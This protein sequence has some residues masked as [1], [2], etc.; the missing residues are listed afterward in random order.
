MKL[1]QLVPAQQIEPNTKIRRRNLKLGRLS[2]V[3]P[4]PVQWLWPDRI[5]RKVVLFTGLPDCGKT[6]AAIDIAARVTRGSAWPDGSGIAPLGSVIFLTAEDGLA[7][8]IRTRAD[9]AGAD[10]SRIYFLEG[11]HDEKGEPSSFS[12]Q[13][14][15]ALLSEH[16]K[17]IGDVT[18]I[19]ID[20]ITAYLGA[21]KIDTHKTAVDIRRQGPSIVPQ[22]D[23]LATL[24]RRE[25]DAV[26]A[27]LSNEIGM[28]YSPPAAGELVA[29]TF[30]QRLTLNSGRFALIDNGLG[31]ALVPWT[32][33]LDR[34][35]GPSC[36]RRRQGERRDR[37]EF[38]TQARAGDLIAPLARKGARRAMLG[39]PRGPT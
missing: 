5:A 35:L 18:L 14:D 20:P 19:V 26:D 37:V 10:A 3:M 39:F 32:P 9:A 21:G 33:A 1:E 29:G 30:R 27:R 34:H 31:F 6:T 28:P 2:D 15:L 36:R 11:M 13:Q 7:D 38:R 24:R 4:Q 8:T 23:L 25:L 16:V 22:R 17:E 12:L